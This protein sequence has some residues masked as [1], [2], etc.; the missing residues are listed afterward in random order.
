MIAFLKKRLAASICLLIGLLILAPSVW[1]MI[2]QASDLPL[3]AESTA[4]GYWDP[5]LT[6][7]TAPETSTHVTSVPNAT[8]PFIPDVTEPAIPDVTEPTIPDVTEP[9]IPDVTEP[10]QPP[11]THNWNAATCTLP[12]IC[13]D[14]GVSDGQPLGHAWDEGV[15][16]KPATEE[17]EGEICF[18]CTICQ[19]TQLQILPQLSHIHDYSNQ[20]IVEPTC[21]ANGYFFYTCRCGESYIV[22]AIPAL[23]HNF[24]SATCIEPAVCHRCGVQEGQALGHSWDAGQIRLPATEETEG[25]RQF[26]CTICG[27]TQ[28]QAI[29]ALGHT[30]AYQAKIVSPTCT[31]GGYT[32]YTCNCG[33]GYTANETAMLN[34]DWSAATCLSPSVCNRCGITE[35]QALGHSWNEGTETR[36]ATE[37]TE[38][39]ILYRCTACGE[40]RTQ[41]IPALGHTHNHIA[42]ITPATCTAEGYTTYTCR[43][44]DSYIADNTPALEHDWIP[45]TCTTAK[46]CR[47]CK[48]VE[49]TS[50][51]H[52]WN[53]GVITIPATE[54]TEG[55]K[56]FTCTACNATRT[57]SIPRL[58]HTHRYSATVTAP[59]CTTG[60][61]TTYVCPCGDHYISN[62]RPASG[63]QWAAATCTA[64]QKCTVCGTKVGDPLAHI[65]DNGTVIRPATEET[66]GEILYHC[67]TCAAE[68]RQTLPV[69]NHTHAFTVDSVT[70]PTCTTGGYT[71]Y[72][73]RCGERYVADQTNA[74]GHDWKNA[75]CTTAKTCS[76]C[77]TT[78][79]PALGH[80]WD[81]GVV[82]KPA[83]EE[84]EGTKLFACTACGITKTQ[85]IPKLEHAHNYVAT[86]TAPTCTEIGYTFYVCRC[87]NNY[88]GN[89]TP[90]T[91]HDW[92]T[93]TCNA[94]ARCRICGKTEGAARDHQWNAG[95]VTKPA[96]EEAEGSKLFTCTACGTT[97]TQ[98]I[99]KLEHTH[100]YSETV[101]APTC[102]ANGY[103]TYICGCGH[104]YTDKQ[105]PALGH[106]WKATVTAPTCTESGFTTY[107]CH[108]GN[109]YT[110]NETPA[111]GHD[112]IDATYTSPKTCKVCYITTGDPLPSIIK[113]AQITL[114]RP[115]A[116]G[117]EVKSNKYATIDYSNTKDGYVMVKYLAETEKQLMVQVTGA[118]TTYTYMIVPNEWTVFPLSDGNGDY[119]IKVYQNVDGDRY[120]TKLT[121]T[122]HVQ[123]EDEFAPFLR[124]NQYVNYENATQ[125][126]NT[127]AALLTDQMSML[128]KVKI[129][130][131]YVTTNITYDYNKIDTLQS[132]YVP[133]LDL[134][135]QQ[136][137]GICFDYAA[138]MTAMLRTQNIPCK[139]VVGFA[140]GGYH[141]WISVWSSETGWIDG[142]IYFSG[143]DWEL[144]D[145]TFAANGADITK[146]NYVW[147]YI[148]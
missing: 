15:V 68:K 108:C 3:P 114:L 51:G 46:A 63:H 90:A 70:A 80:C 92:M 134:V 85:S 62:E 84:A 136:K 74:L 10:S 1:L 60:G 104:R 87:G 39:E 16:T 116:S 96:T 13:T 41:S 88:R 47:I 58:E 12:A 20:Q 18:T 49:G 48:T 82:S 77:G 31:T 144:L 72:T 97:K 57:Q 27:A 123:L 117:T 102:T 26:T 69:L 6:T 79:G 112:W 25:I 34:H 43:C 22:D 33:D 37:E 111:N 135:L 5:S 54:E 53:D 100:R 103:T 50:L 75:T 45:A 119:T 76:I 56:L 14:C 30:H 35:G 145:P 93:A 99:P 141:A 138:L 146:V 29:P 131:D 125:T 109:R 38:G 147:K 98:V 132:G 21:T 7:P 89:E 115:V 118:T 52:R 106:N 121:L 129:I 137:T 4:S 66:E 55:A 83:T 113:P 71:T 148:Y 28:I 107:V 86:V 2:R 42:T 8:E 67:T 143:T 61:Y 139:L 9:T 59:T 81:N 95:V 19:E 11:H 105:T 140:D 127:A 78:E 23:G 64:A 126:M 73:C 36:P 32:T 122:T 44:G 133:D 40:T 142:A 120:A 24:D 130:Y 101:T 65:W 128:E 91:G 124:P 94:P 110:S 17:A